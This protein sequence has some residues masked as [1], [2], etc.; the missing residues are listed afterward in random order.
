M[1]KCVE[2]EPPLSRQRPT[3]LVAIGLGRQDSKSVRIGGKHQ[4][5][6]IPDCGG[7]SGSSS[8]D[9]AVVLSV[10][11]LDKEVAVSIGACHHRL[12][13]L[14]PCAAPAAA[15]LPDDDDDDDDWEDRHHEAPSPPEEPDVDERMMEALGSAGMFV[16]GGRS[17]YDPHRHGGLGMG[18]TM[19]K[20]SAPGMLA[21]EMAPPPKQPKQLTAKPPP[22]KPPP[23]KQPPPKP[24]PPKQP[25]EAELATA[26]AAAASAAAA[27]REA[28]RLKKEE[29]ENRKIKEAVT[30][31]LELLLK[32]LEAQKRRE[33]SEH[34][35]MFA[36]LA[37]R[38][39]QKRREENERAKMFA[40]L[41]KYVTDC[42]G[43]AS[44]VDGFTLGMEKCADAHTGGMVTVQVWCAPA[45]QL[46]FRSRVDVAR[47]FEL[48]KPKRGGGSVASPS[49]AAGG[50][51]GARKR[52]RVVD[53][54]AAD[55]DDD[56]DDVVRAGAPKRKTTSVSVKLQRI[57][58]SLGIAL[59]DDNQITAVHAGG[60][61]AIAGL[62]VG[63]V[64][65]EVDGK[66]VHLASFGSLLPKEKDAVI[67][68]RVRRFVETEEKAPK[69]GEREGE[70]AAKKDH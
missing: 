21:C 10:A 2:A 14:P 43:N 61:G 52:T 38:E 11:D 70:R 69:A 51:N 57:G 58:G 55:D 25:S 31:W 49:A 41:V 59:S 35:K 42:G 46:T 20:R 68:M 29:E 18:N 50:G 8:S 37:K 22:P 28:R 39:A 64:V 54:D 7:P 23:P 4:V 6:D 67:T 60:A 34:S 3:R 56:D 24:P 30:K 63:D 44:L 65:N 15:A 5:D 45:G 9:I 16:G 13:L 66:S 1:L 47:H 62:K 36:E 27:A 32:T 19:G 33:E 17:S 48:I 53:D 26:A 12:A 40:E